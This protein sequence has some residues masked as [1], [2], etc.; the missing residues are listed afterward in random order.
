MHSS[1]FLTLDGTCTDPKLVCKQQK[2]SQL[3]VP[4]STK[5]LK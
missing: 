5:V 2:F 1:E 3:Y 4:V